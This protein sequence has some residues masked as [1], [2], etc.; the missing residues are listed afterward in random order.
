M[1]SVAILILTLLSV[2]AWS[3]QL[4]YDD[5]TETQVISAKERTGANV[6]FISGLTNMHTMVWCFSTEEEAQ[7]HV[8]MRGQVA[9]VS[10]STFIA[11]KKTDSSKP[12][13]RMLKVVCN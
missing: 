6:E 1:K 3:E 11:S 10:G 4:T 8:A 5:I 12:N 7:K 13:I 2:Q 9:L